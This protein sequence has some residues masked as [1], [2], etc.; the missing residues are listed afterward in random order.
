MPTTPRH[1][2]RAWA[3]A[4]AAAALV[5]TVAACVPEPGP[6]GS[7]APTTT[8]SGTSSAAPSASSAAPSPSTTPTATAAAGDISLPSSCEQIYSAGMLAS[9]NE[10]T[11]PLNDPGVTL[12]STQISEA[13]EVLD[14]APT[15]RCSWGTPSESGLAT[16]VTIVDAAQAAAVQTGLAN[17]GIGCESTLDGTLCA[18]STQSL[19]LDNVLVTRGETHFLRGNGWVSTS[20]ISIDPE[21]YTPDIVSTLWG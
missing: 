4:L 10:T 13:L 14:A 6:S 2:T 17:A 11:P 21:G 7:A 12:L 16:N 5:L 19:T 8:P 3:A 9:L 15:I 20:W 1:A 18:A